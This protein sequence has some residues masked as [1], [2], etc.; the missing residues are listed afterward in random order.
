M[1][2]ENKEV[3]DCCKNNKG[4]GC[5]PAGAVYGMG[6]VG[7]AVYFIQHASGFWV[8]VMGVLKAII[9]PA[10]LVYKFFEFFKF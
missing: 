10:F 9:W 4:G 7:A 8:G 3:R 6:F 5:A 1:E 2:Q